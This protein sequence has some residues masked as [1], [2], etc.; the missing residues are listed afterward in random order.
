MNRG[1]ISYS[2][3]HLF[4]YILALFILWE[5]LRPIPIVTDTAEIGWFVAFAFVSA[6]FIYLRIPLYVMLPLLF[7]F[8][9]WGLHEL[10]GEG[11]LFS[12]EGASAVIWRFIE[13]FRQNASVIWG[14]DFSGLTNFF[15]TFLL[16]VLIS[17]IVYLLYYW[18]F[19]TRRVFFF[20]LATI[21]YITVLDTFT[22]AD[23][24]QAVVRI[25][26]IGFFMITLLHL[27]GIQEEEQMIGRRSKT[28]VPAAW[29]YTLII[30]ATAAAAVGMLA[31]KPEPQ[32]DDPVP[33]MQAFVTGDEGSETVSRV[34]YGDNDE[35]LG[36]GFIQDGG[37]VFEALAE[38]P[39]YWR[40]ETKD[41]YTG[42]GWETSNEDFRDSLTYGAEGQI[43]YY[44]Y[45]FI[46]PPDFIDEEDVSRRSAEIAMA[47]EAE[48]SHLFYPGQLLNAE[49]G[50]ITAETGGETISGN[51]LDF[52]TDRLNGRINASSAG[53]DA[54]LQ[55][56]TLDY[57]DVTF[58]I[59]EL[60]E[61]SEDDPDGITGR[62]LQLPDDLPERVIDLAAELTEDEDNRYDQAVAVED[63]LHGPDFDYVT[64]DVAVPGEDEDYVDQFL[65][66]TQE[67][68][69]DNYSTAMVVLLRAADI[70]A[71]WV[72]GFTAG[73]EIENGEDMNRYEV[74]NAN[75]HSWVEVYFPEV[76]WIPFEPTQGFDNY[77]DFEEDFDIDIDDTEDENDEQPGEQENDPFLNEDTADNEREGAE[78]IGAAVDRFAGTGFT[79]LIMITLAVVILSIGM[80]VN[81]H[82]ILRRVYM[83]YYSVLKQDKTFDAAYSRLLWL[84]GDRG[85][86]KRSDE[87]LREYAHRIDKVFR[88]SEMTKLTEVY[89]RRYYGG[90]TTDDDWLSNKDRWEFMMEKIN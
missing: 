18:V 65:F 14:G 81:K 8:S 42:R 56:Y 87:T 35:E 12:R 7:L 64:E 15:R 49:I 34:G 78:G 86:P 88:T 5:W 61:L 63:H 20:L 1:V 50:N 77:A 84:I 70:P 82:R 57:M 40:G 28:F 36:G 59:H 73:E 85:Y 17:L 80:Y 21:V 29:L 54:Q 11:T 60:R 66:E 10:F 2:L 41:V 27:S 9:L 89:E 90:V 23:A 30:M 69:C 33:S 55:N 3:L 43:D 79:E 24:S 4:V 13:E 83:Q 75:A 45:D 44:L 6:A 76:G 19:Q 51:D 39:V 71:R 26:V 46:E 47:D 31:P 67:G 16:F 58:P 74:T 72:K 37:P 25:V 68:Y 62:Y 53:A 32:W 52:Q 38:E 22:E 48:F